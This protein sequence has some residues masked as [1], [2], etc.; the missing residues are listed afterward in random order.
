MILSGDDLHAARLEL[1]YS[2]SE[3]ATKLRLGGDGARRV[4]DME[5]GTRPLTG[6]CAVAVELMLRLHDRPAGR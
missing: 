3:L 6:P 2:V 5:M 4:R 1:G